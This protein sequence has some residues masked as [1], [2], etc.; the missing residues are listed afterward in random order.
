M[1]LCPKVLAM[2]RWRFKNGQSGQQDNGVN[3]NGADDI[4][5]VGVLKEIQIL[6]QKMDGDNC[7]M[8]TLGYYRY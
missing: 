4:Y 3:I 6:N 5:S 1:Y 7:S 8:A 2:L